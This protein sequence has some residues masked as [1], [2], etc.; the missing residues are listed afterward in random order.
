MPQRTPP[1]KQKKPTDAA[2]P[3][4]ILRVPEAL[5]AVAVASQGSSLADLSARLAVPKT[6]LHRLLR[7]LESGGYLIYQS[8]EYS[9]GP[10][11][12]HLA[13]LINKAAP[14]NAFPN[15][16][17]PVMEW[18]AQATHETVLLGVLTENN[19]EIQY[20]DAIDSAAS[21]RFSV[22]IGDRRALYSAASGKAVLAFLPSAVQKHYIERTAF[23]QFT[24]FTSRKKELPALLREIRSKACA[25]DRNGKVIGASGIASPIFTGDG[26]VIAS[27]SAAGPTERIEANRK[28]IESN[29]RQAGERISRLLGYSGAYPPP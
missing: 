4:A 20:V 16:A 21:V 9:L 22:S 6:S 28:R 13:A 12:F 10:A 1:T 19:T 17:R 29:V 7:T 14:S 23:K 25:F 27:I 24:T 18:L 8:G 5:V 15:C 2:G 11:S 26:K 3:R